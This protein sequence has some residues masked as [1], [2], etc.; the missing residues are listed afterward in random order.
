MYNSPLQR[1]EAVNKA[2]MSGREIE[3]AVLSKAAL[4]LKKCQDNW[5][6]DDIDKKLKEALEYNQQIWSILQGELVKP[7]HPLPRQIR[8]N[9]LALSAFIDK[10]VFEI[11]AFPA[12]E[13]LN[14]VIDINRNIAA[15][16][17]QAASVGR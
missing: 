1:Y 4:K 17:R 6:A 8:Y 12:P 14:I 7:D 5:D 13:K 2:T 9:L 15:G 16:L 3:A 10:S 11:M